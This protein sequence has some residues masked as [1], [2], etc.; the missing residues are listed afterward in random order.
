MSVKESWRLTR[1][2]SWRLLGAFILVGLTGIV[3]AAV[4]QLVAFLVGAAIA[5]PAG[6]TLGKIVPYLNVLGANVCSMIVI[7]ALATLFAFIYRDLT[8]PTKVPAPA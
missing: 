1:G 6:I 4:S 8:T 2:L 5:L 7:F 3:M